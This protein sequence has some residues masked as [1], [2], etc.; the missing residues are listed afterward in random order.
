MGRLLVI[1]ND[2]PPRPGGIQAFVHAI[3]TRLAARG[4][5]VTVYAP[6]WPGAA[7]FDAAQPYP[8]VRHPT[9]LMLPTPDVARRARSLLAATQADTVWFGAA[10]P[11]GFLAPLLR[12][13]GARR[14]VA[15]THGHELAWLRFP[16]ARQ[17]FVHLARRLD[18]L[19]YLGA[20]THRRLARAIGPGARLARLSPGVDPA[21]FHPGVDGSAV[22][23]RH[24]LGDDPVVVCVSR[25][26]PRKGQD[27]LIRA[28]TPLRR[29]IPGAR[30]LLVGDGPYRSRLQQLAA[31]YAVSDAVVFAGAVSWSELP[32]YY[33]AGNVFAMPC[34]DRWFHLDVEGFGI[35]YLEAAATGLPVVA[36]T[37][38]GAP[39]AVPP[40]GGV[41]VD[42]R[43]P[44]ALVDVLAE[45]LSDPKRAAEMGEAARAWVVAHATWD[46]AAARLAQLLNGELVES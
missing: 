44:A 12:R 28:L 31:R 43:D 20:Y 7:E 3:V 10:A 40:G 21:V 41:V 39:E 36:G 37:S 2:F 45:L 26:V 5:Q 35:V 23:R 33:A 17:L 14:I 18:V 46:A 8:V 9:S 32:A 29:R 1:S 6:A 22:R 24:R 16:G 25:L 15:S 38:G 11:L 30:L 27:M 34:R 4:C 13:S 19:T 42:G